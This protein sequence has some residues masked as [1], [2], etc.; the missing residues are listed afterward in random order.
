MAKFYDIAE[1]M[2][3]GRQ[4]PEVKLDDEHVYKI[5]TSKS[6]VLYIQGI[7][8]D[9]SKDDIAKLDEVIKVALGKVA[10]EYIDSLDPSMEILTLII[11]TIMAAISGIDLEEAEAATK[12]AAKKAQKKSK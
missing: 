8:D 5:N 3:V 7:Y 2:Q 10:A 12:E 1:R 9:K 4:K 6:A 11:E